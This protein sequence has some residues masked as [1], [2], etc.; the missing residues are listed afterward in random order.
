MNNLITGLQHIGI[1]VC[2]LE[3]SIAFY[4]QLSFTCIHTKNIERSEGHIRVAFMKL[5]DLVIEL[6]EF[7]GLYLHEIRSRQHGHVDHIAL[8]VTDIEYAF[9]KFKVE[10]MHLLDEE[11]QSIPFFENGVRFFTIQGPN[12]EK[13]ELNQRL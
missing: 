8:N 13:I 5:N 7:E 10:G 4:K 12:N 2:N 11:I 6:Y 9:K 1:P 3:E